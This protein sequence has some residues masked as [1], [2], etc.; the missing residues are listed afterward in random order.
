MIHWLI[1]LGTR[2]RTQ[3]LDQR[4]EQGGWTTSSPTISFV[5]CR[6]LSLPVRDC[7]GLCFRAWPPFPINR[8]AKLTPPLGLSATNRRNPC[9]AVNRADSNF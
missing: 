5:E 8:V 3:E 9:D 4:R 6:R 1:P 7:L 2:G